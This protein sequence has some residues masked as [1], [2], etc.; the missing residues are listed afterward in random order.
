MPQISR[1]LNFKSIVFTDIESVVHDA[2]LTFPFASVIL[3]PGGFNKNLGKKHVRINS[4]KECAYINGNFVPDPSVL[5]NIGLSEGERLVVLR[6]VS[7]SA[8]HDFGYKGISDDLKI[9]LVDAL[10]SFSKILICSEDPLPEV[11]EK[12][13][14]DI[15][16]EKIHSVLYYAS[17]LYGES[18]TM[19]AEAALM[20][21]PAIFVDKNGRGYTREIESRSGLLFN[22]TLAENGFEN[23]IE[24]AINI[25]QSPLPPK[26][27]HQKRFFPDQKTVDISK[28][29]I[30]I[31]TK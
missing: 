15:E 1:V 23:S 12:Y 9:E 16:P 20:G 26:K 30:D 24:K 27:Q 17:L 6:F 11:L 10:S 7:H 13:R 21:T 4:Y 5:K 8:A 19:A 14:L 18:S 31:L 3:T 2:W 28:L 25:L 22:F 29:L